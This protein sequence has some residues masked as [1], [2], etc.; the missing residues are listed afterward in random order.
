[1]SRS[2]EDFVR[3]LVSIEPELEAELSE[4]IDDNDGVLP[5]LFMGDVA[6]WAVRSGSTVVGKPRLERLLGFLED[7]YGDGTSDTANVIAASFVE[8]MVDEP[9]IVAMFGPKLT[10]FYRV[11]VGDESLNAGESTPMPRVCPNCRR[12][13]AETLR[14]NPRTA[15]RF[16]E[17]QA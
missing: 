14:R 7:A 15:A 16:P 13:C 11:F 3:E 2:P 10:H 17:S 12:S 8:F 1:M 4:H 6:R 5:H 9:G